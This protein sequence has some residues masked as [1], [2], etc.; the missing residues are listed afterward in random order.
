MNRVCVSKKTLT[1]ARTSCLWLMV[2][3]LAGCTGSTPAPIVIGHV[4]DKTR[5][6][7]AG[8]QAELGIR[9]ALHELTQDGTISETFG[10]RKIEVH[11]TDTRGKLDA[12]ESQAVRL[13][14]VNR[15]LAIF[16]GLSSSATLAL[17][18]AKAPLLTFSGYAP[19]G[20]TNLVFCL[21]LAPA[22]QG[23]ALAEV[24][25]KDTKA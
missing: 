20:A 8:E 23:T 15:C 2:L 9:L 5:A 14:S 25:A 16:G 7:K 17:N 4:S 11:H 22:R 13:D 19:S 21:G 3:A 6:D 10:G 1:I 24:V 18:N 12:F